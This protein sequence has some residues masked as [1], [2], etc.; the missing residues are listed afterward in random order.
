VSLTCQVCLWDAQKLENIQTIRD[1]KQAALHN[2]L[3]S[4]FFFKTEGK[5]ILGTNKM[6]E[7]RLKID[8]DVMIEVQKQDVIAQDYIKG[9][10]LL[11]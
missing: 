6:H 9:K 4:S 8:N 3:S 11:V 7:W 5:L 1:S 2:A 10:C